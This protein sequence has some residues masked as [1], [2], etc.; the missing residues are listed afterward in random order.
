MIDHDVLQSFRFH[1][2]KSAGLANLAR[3]AGRALTSGASTPGAVGALGGAAIGGTKAYRDSDGDMLSTIV[4][5]VRGGV[6]GGAAGAAVGGLGRAARDAK[7]MGHKGN[8]VVGGIKRLGSSAKRGLKTQA[9]GVTGAYSKNRGAMSLASTESAAAKN[10][11]LAGRLKDDLAHARRVGAGTEKIKGIMS[12]AKD[13]M[14]A[15]TTAGA[16]GSR[17]IDE[18]VTSLPGVVKGLVKNPKAMGKKLWNKTTGGT[19]KGAIVP[20]GLPVAS[21]VHAL[22]KGDESGQG[23]LTRMQKLRNTALDTGAMVATGGLPLAAGFAAFG[24]S[25]KLKAQAAKGKKA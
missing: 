9:H 22:S 3:S 8:A 6:V 24:A 13:R 19:V 15:V 2:E 10:K 18:G 23:G 14:K 5:G 17:H 4:G 11:L 1:V 7:I 25:D 21:G 12:T 16:E 20:V